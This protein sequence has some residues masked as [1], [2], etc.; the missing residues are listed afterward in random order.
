MPIGQNLIKHIYI[1]YVFCICVCARVFVS[2]LT[3]IDRF[4]TAYYVF[5]TINA[6]KID[7]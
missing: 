2:G 5:V 1:I 7:Y 6:Q 4:L 3:K